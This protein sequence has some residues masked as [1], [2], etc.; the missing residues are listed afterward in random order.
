M[1]QTKKKTERNKIYQV[2]ENTFIIEVLLA[3]MK[4][5]KGIYKIIHNHN[6]LL[7]IYELS[8]S[9]I[10]CRILWSNSERQHSSKS[11]ECE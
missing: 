1:S 9:L 6:Q 10:G 5:A 11:V 4:N 3:T 7:I 8:Q 2:W